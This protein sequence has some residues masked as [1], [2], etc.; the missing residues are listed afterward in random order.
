MSAHKPSANTIDRRTR[1]E[2]QNHEFMATANH[3]RILIL[4]FWHQFEFLFTSWRA[5]SAFSFYFSILFSILCLKM[6][7]FPYFVRS[8]WPKIDLPNADHL[9]AEAMY[10]LF[11]DNARPSIHVSASS[12]QK[13]KNPKICS[14]RSERVSGRL[15]WEGIR[16]Q[17]D[18]WLRL[19]LDV[20][21]EHHWSV[22]C[23]PL[24]CN[25]GWWWDEL[26]SDVLHTAAV[27]GAAG[28]AAHNTP[29]QKWNEKH[30]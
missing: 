28:A 11:S 3:C 9:N 18:V 13:Q 2:Q 15:P 19:K 26:V 22:L 23:M 30:N 10:R 14:F 20:N 27:C 16:L 7:I 4:V 24:Q 8:I 29:C 17:L 25:H 12:F 6:M 5:A 21:N 1:R